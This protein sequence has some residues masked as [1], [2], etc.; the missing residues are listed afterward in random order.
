[1]AATCHTA[2]H[3]P[4]RQRYRPR[5]PLY[6]HFA[7]CASLL[8]TPL[9]IRDNFHDL[10]PVDRNASDSRACASWSGERDSHPLVSKILP[11][12]PD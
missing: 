1:M 11:P 3:H 8:I 10:S 2:L 5:I 12:L 9:P 4:I 6:Q 7:P